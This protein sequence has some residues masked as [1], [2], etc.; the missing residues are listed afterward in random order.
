MS[1]L[2]TLQ[3]H[4]T[5]SHFPSLTMP[6]YTGPN[7]AF[8]GKIVSKEQLAELQKADKRAAKESAAAA[9]STPPS[10]SSSAVPLAT[11]KPGQSDAAFLQ[12]SAVAAVA[13][14]DST[15]TEVLSIR[16]IRWDDEEEER[17][18]RVVLRDAGFAGSH[19]DF[20]LFHGFIGEK[21]YIFEVHPTLLKNTAAMKKLQAPEPNVIVH[22]VDLGYVERMERVR[23]ITANST[24]AG[25]GSCGEGKLTPV[26]RHIVH[27]YIE[28][29]ID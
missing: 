26:Q 19:K 11:K 17:M 24:A 4:T 29:I 21:E 2:Y 22:T 23:V 9:K 15:Y 20:P 28:A 6:I 16:P 5:K 12:E 10:A 8:T 14:G 18:G 1:I 3:I 7:S 25:G 13:A 27:R